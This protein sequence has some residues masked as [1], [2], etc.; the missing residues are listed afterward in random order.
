MNVCF[1]LSE[2]SDSV[3]KHILSASISPPLSHVWAPSGAPSGERL[4]VCIHTGRGRGGGRASIS[5][6]LQDEGE[7]K[8][9]KR[10]PLNNRLAR[11]SWEVGE[12][13]RNG[14]SGR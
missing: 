8:V 14:Q 11:R 13:R 3:S 12:L 4:H 10:G 2:R 9:R 6:I 5:R 7:S 1:V